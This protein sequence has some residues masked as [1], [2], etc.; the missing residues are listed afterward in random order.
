MTQ[1]IHPYID[2]IPRGELEAITLEQVLTKTNPKFFGPDKVE[3]EGLAARIIKKTTGKTIAQLIT[4]KVL[5]PL[6]LLNTEWMAVPKESMVCD[7]TA[8]DGHASVRLKS[9]EGHERNLYM[10]AKDLAYWGYLYLNNGIVNEIH[11]IPRAVFELSE[12]LRTTSAKRVMGWYYQED[13]FEA[14]GATGCHLVVIPK[15][16]T[17]AVRMYNQYAREHTETLLKC[18]QNITPSKVRL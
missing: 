4:E 16:N 12:R 14:D 11:I 5:D 8:G 3:A 1:P 18:L 9:D 7:Y 10:T 17:V 15:Y 13:L 2:D 6:Q